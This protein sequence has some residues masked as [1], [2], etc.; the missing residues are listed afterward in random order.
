MKLLISLVEIFEGIREVIR[1][2]CIQ[3]VFL[4]QWEESKASH[5]DC[6]ARLF[7]FISLSL[8]EAQT[9]LLINIRRRKILSDSCFRSR[10]RICF[11]IFGFLRL[12]SSFSQSLQFGLLLV[13]LNHPSRISPLRLELSF[14]GRCETSF[15]LGDVHIFLLARNDLLDK[16]II[17]LTIFLSIFVIFVRVRADVKFEWISGLTSEFTSDF[18]L[19][20][21]LWVL[22]LYVFFLKLIFIMFRESIDRFLV[23]LLLLLKL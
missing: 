12:L 15:S 14:H 6:F 4:L 8:E 19:L 11:L 2:T 3:I 5:V 23:S 7:F 21:K 17:F 13:R 18:N 9:G 1:G 22:R 20:L 10:G 16:E